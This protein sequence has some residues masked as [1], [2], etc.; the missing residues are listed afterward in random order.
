MVGT[1]TRKGFGVVQA[2]GRHRSYDLEI[3]DVPHW[4]AAVPWQPGP[5]RY[6]VKALHRPRA[7]AK[8]DPRFKVGAR[9]GRM[10]GR[11]D[12]ETKAAA[13]ELERNLDADPPDGI[14]PIAV[15]G[16]ALVHELFDRALEGRHSRRFVKDFRSMCEFHAM[17]P[18]RHCPAVRE[19]LR[20]S[21]TGAEIVKGY[22]DLDG[23][24]VIAGD[25]YTLVSRAEMSSRIALDSVG[26]EGVK[27]R[28]LGQIPNGSSL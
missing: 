6:E 11:R 2:G 7:R 1:L 19:Y 12:A 13:L 22:C 3:V 10:Y 16:V 17:D 20:G 21:V 25:T 18:S 14:G 26:S 5:G 28:Y 24:F 9:G 8:F 4:A 15:A 27:L 23:L